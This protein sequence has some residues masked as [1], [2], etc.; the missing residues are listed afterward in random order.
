MAFLM[1]GTQGSSERWRIPGLGKGKY[2]M[3]P[4]HFVLPE[5]Q[6]VIKNDAGW[7]TRLSVKGLLGARDETISAQNSLLVTQAGPP[8]LLSLWPCRQPRPSGSALVYTG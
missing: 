1:E 5:S 8:E 3:T 2:K 6:E 7:V 4:E